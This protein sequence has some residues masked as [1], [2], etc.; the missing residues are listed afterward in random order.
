VDQPRTTRF[1]RR[2]PLVAGVVLLVVLPI[3]AVFTGL[4][5]IST[6][7]Y[8]PLAWIALL[9]AVAA[10]VL[11]VVAVEPHERTRRRAVALTL[12]GLSLCMVLLFPLT[13]V[14]PVGALMGDSYTATEWLGFARIAVPHLVQLLMLP[15]FAVIAAGVAARLSR[16][17]M[18]PIRWIAVTAWVLAAAQFSLTVLTGL[19]GIKDDLL[20]AGG[21][22]AAEALEPAARLASVQIVVAVALPIVLVALSVLLFRAG[23]GSL[24][25]I[26]GGPIRSDA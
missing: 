6:V 9:D 14:V 7:R 3:V 20:V 5:T 18:G 19:E 13:P 26:S 25:E 1:F 17:G 4:F 22:G 12:A 10:V 23:R 16:R 21:L 24:V 15:A 8:E 11:L 2:P